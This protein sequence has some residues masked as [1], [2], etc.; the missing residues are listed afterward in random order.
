M[1]E[2]ANELG[3]ELLTSCRSRT[4]RQK[5]ISNVRKVSRK[6]F[7]NLRMMHDTG[8]DSDRDIADMI[9]NHKNTGE[10]NFN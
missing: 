4:G 2:V 7:G 1:E 5:M 8:Y 9:Q 10:V 6:I 3:S